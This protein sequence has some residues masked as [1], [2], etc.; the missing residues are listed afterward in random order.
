M[1]ENWLEYKEKVDARY[2]FKI[3]EITEKQSPD[4]SL[5][6]FL[7]EKIISSY[8]SFEFYNFHFGDSATEDEIRQYV[9]NQVIPKDDNQFDRN[10]R[11]GDWGEIV[12][13]LIVSYFQNLIIPISKLQWKFNK[14]KAVFGTDLIAFNNGPVIEDIHYYEIKTRQNPHNKEGKIPARFYVSIWAHNSLLK[15]ELSPTESIADF[16][17]RLY[18]EKGDYDTA[19]KFKD[20]VK[21][22]QNYNKKFE[23]FLIVEKD[24]FTDII[25]NELNNL[26]PKLDPLNVTIVLIDNL[27]SL[28]NKTWHDIE[29]VLVDKVKA[30]L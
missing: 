23:L 25:L 4:D 12:S 6:K 2:V 8:R 30:K 10:V 24:K 15:D 17:E 13:G 7:Q 11:Q 5:V 26:P 29:T 21:N 9:K 22:P 27:G 3:V 18:V 16:L 28:V 20:I 19:L 14:D 1:I